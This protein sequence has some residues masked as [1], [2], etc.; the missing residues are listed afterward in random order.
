MTTNSKFICSVFVIVMIGMFA[1]SD[2][3]QAKKRHR[4]NQW[5]RQRANVTPWNGAYRH[6]AYSTPLARDR[7]SN[8]NVF[9]FTRLGRFQKRRCATVPPIPTWCTTTKPSWLRTL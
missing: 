4:V 2:T 5:E 3:V 9:P 6:Q 7:S 1:T 8:R